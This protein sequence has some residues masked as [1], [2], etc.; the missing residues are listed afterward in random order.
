MANR[1][2]SLDPKVFCIRDLKREGSKC[3]PPVYRGIYYTLHNAMITEDVRLFQWRCH[4]YDNVRVDFYPD[5]SNKGSDVSR[6]RENEE[7]FDRYKIRPR[8]LRNVSDIDTS[9][10]ILGYKVWM[11]EGCVPSRKLTIPAGSFPMWSEPNRYAQARTSRR[12]TS[13]ISSR[14]A[15]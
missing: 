7:A 13:D 15:D 3:L 12:G 5:Q 10:E 11:Y 1:A 2:P 4:G 8:V 6:L 9:F 14:S